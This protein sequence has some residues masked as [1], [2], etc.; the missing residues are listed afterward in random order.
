MFQ[1]KNGPLAS[2][3]LSNSG[4]A[5]IG[6]IRTLE[7]HR[8]QLH[9]SLTTNHPQTGASQEIA[10]PTMDTPFMDV[11]RLPEDSSGIIMLVGWSRA[12]QAQ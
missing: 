3:W 9:C 5:F 2:S 6:L 4:M 11:P 8:W 1:Y 10:D 12:G 7:L